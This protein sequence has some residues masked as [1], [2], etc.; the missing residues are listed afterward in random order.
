[1]ADVTSTPIPVIQHEK[2]VPTKSAVWL[3]WADCMCTLLCSFAEGSTLSYFFVYRLL[4]D[5]KWASIVWILFGI[6]NA[7]NDPI[8]GFIADR[9]KSKLGRRIPWIRYGAP[10]LAGLFILTWVMFPSMEGNQLFLAFQMAIT[11]FF[12]DIVYT[13]VASALYVMPYEMAVTNAARSP[14]FVWKIAFA[15]ISTGV[16]MFL[17]SYLSNILAQGYPTFMWIMVGLGIFGGL[18]IFFSTFFYK[19]NGYVKDEP[20]PP[21]WKGLLACLKNKSFLLFE[22]ISFTVMYAQSNLMSGLAAVWPMWNASYMGDMSMY[23]CYG[24]MLI[25]AVLALLLYLK[26]REKWGAK[27]LTLIMCAGF[28]LGCFI[29]AF[30]GRYFWAMVIAFFFIGVGFA[31]GMYLIPIINGDVIDKDE[32]INGSRREGTYAGVNSL[33]TKPAQ[34]IAQASFLAILASYGLDKTNM[35]TNPDTGEQ[36]L[37]WAG[38]IDSVKNGVFIAWLLIPGILLVLSFVAMYFFPLHGKEWDEEKNALAKKHAD[39]EAAFEQQVLK[40]E[41]AA[42]KPSETK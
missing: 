8:Y 40:E 10:F 19:E 14:I 39:K 11:L 41:A 9:T 32:L 24:A 35:I 21:F 5:E 33:I 36:S 38:Q 17:N 3:S 12:F 31:G 23:V 15:L 13:A 30:L 25:G 18:V 34:S 37:N 16:P 1:M 22:A 26:M 27:N 7:I 6:W 28:A 42:E 20:Q 29:G 4:L 2:K